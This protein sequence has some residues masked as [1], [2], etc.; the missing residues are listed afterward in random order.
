MSSLILTSD[1]YIS[2]NGALEYEAPAL[3]FTPTNSQIGVVLV[4]QYAYTNSNYNLGASTTAVQTLFPFANGGS[5]N[6]DIGTYE[7]ECL[8]NLSGMSSSSGSFGF[9]LG[10][11]ATKS[12]RW[13]SIASKATLATA[14][15]PQVTLNTAA[16]TTLAT[17]TTATVGF[18]QITGTCVVTVAGTLTPQ[19][20]VTVAAAPGVNSGSYFKIRALA[21]E[22][23][24]YVGNW[25]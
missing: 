21:N 9:A 17:A 14:V 15:A 22:T 13:M 24:Y 7:F 12:E 5:V 11:T 25:G 18:A 4:D 2:T 8:F 1:A 20:S 10:G 23:P 3:Y 16:N 6:L 19:A